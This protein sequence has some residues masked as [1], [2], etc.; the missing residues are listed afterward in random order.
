MANDQPIDKNLLKEINKQARN[1]VA[2]DT[3]EQFKKKISESIVSVTV[4]PLKDLFSTKGVSNLITTATGSPVIGNILEGFSD[5]TGG[6]VD[7]FRSTKEDLSEEFGKDDSDKLEEIAKASEIEVDF[8]SDLKR[9]FQDLIAINESL[10]TEEEKKRLHKER[11]QF[12]ILESEK[13]KQ[14]FEIDVNEQE[15]SDEVEKGLTLVGD[16]FE[17]ISNGFSFFLGFASKSLIFSKK[18]LSNITGIFAA[19]EG[20]FFGAKRYLE[21]GDISQTLFAAMGG[22]ISGLTEIIRLPLKLINFI[23]GGSFEQLDNLANFSRQEFNDLFVNVGESF[24]GFI[25]SFINLTIMRFDQLGDSIQNLYESS[26]N[27]IKVKIK[28]NIVDPITNFLDSIKDL[29]INIFD[30]IP[31][32]DLGQND[33]IEL[34]NKQT[35]LI[36]QKRQIIEDPVDLSL[37]DKLLG[38]SQIQA[39]QERLMD[40]NEKLR[41][42]DRDMLRL[43]T[44]TSLITNGSIEPI[45]NIN[46]VIRNPVLNNSME[47]IQ[48]TKENEVLKDKTSNNNSNIIAPTTNAVVNRNNFNTYTTDKSLRNSENTL[49]KINQSNFDNQ[50]I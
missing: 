47:L 7:N 24:I 25:Q 30:K 15:I 40:I 37:T 1:K 38:K 16:V 4:D 43:N 8:M 44:G 49:Q 9:L 31:F 13:E 10:L 11:S 19:V 23:T 34:Q 42:I 50:L 36:E 14:S 39:R 35:Q 29:F 21:T 3:S 41:E 46:E 27:L 5:F 6:L 48:Q 26:I 18:F 45:R 12:D 17:L 32:I 22:V 2:K 28:S 20:I 33:L